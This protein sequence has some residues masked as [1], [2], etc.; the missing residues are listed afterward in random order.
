MEQVV[1]PT[2]Q[3]LD[4]LIQ[5][6]IIVTPILITWFIRTYVKGS[7]AERDIA[8]IVRLSNTAIDYA[9]NLDKRGELVVSPDVSRGIQKLNL[10]S[11]WLE[12][13][14]NRAGVKITN[15]EAQQW[16]SAEFQKRVGDIRLGS[17]VAKLT[18]EAVAMI[19]NLERRQLIDLP[20]EMDRLTYLA[21]LGADWVVAGLAQQ[22]ISLSREE[23]LT[24]VRAAL[25]RQLQVPNENLP[26]TE[27]LI[28]LAKRA[29]D[30]LEELRASGQ[31]QLVGTQETDIAV[32]W[33]V[34]EAAKQGLVISHEEINEAITAVL[35]K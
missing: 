24:F 3:L 31:L 32:A 30:F 14:L 2:E 29:V 4:V 15:D 9:E 1:T 18:Q 19:Q 27:R 10:A 33:L 20:S 34:T 22:S 11:S 25:L 12:S 6:V 13:E 21:G 16:V 23:A 17:A 28:A 8:A 35:S 7:T 26:S 5:V